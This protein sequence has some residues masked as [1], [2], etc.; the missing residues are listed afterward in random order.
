MSG[1][2]V[3]IVGRDRSADIQLVDP[4]VSRL[5]AEFVLG[6]D[7]SLYLADRGSSGGTYVR[8]GD[9]WETVRSAPIDAADVLRLGSYE[10]GAAEL[11]QRA[12]QVA[13]PAAEMPFG[14]VR[15]DPVSGQVIPE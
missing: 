14:R 1:H 6:A 10:V 13:R 15:R 8:R 12:G 2:R 9:R 11:R 5:H 4:S 3:F 7:G